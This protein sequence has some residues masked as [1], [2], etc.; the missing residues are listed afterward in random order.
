[1][2]LSLGRSGDVVRSSHEAKHRASKR[3]FPYVLR[4]RSVKITLHSTKLEASGITKVAQAGKPEQE[5]TAKTMGISHLARE[6]AAGLHARYRSLIRTG[7]ALALA[8][9]LVGGLEGGPN[10]ALPAAS[11]FHKV[12]NPFIQKH[13]I[14]CHGEK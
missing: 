10:D 12:A 2:Y 7:S 11:D 1:M 9:A 4:K 5:K 6:P 14:S 3:L 8:L 13:C